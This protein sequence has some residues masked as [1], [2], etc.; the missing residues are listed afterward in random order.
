MHTHSYLYEHV[1]KVYPYKHF[2]RLDRQIFEIDEVTVDIS[3]LIGMLLTAECIT[4]LNHKVFA[5][6]RNRT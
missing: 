3:L 4:P 6:M 2:R 5:L 1:R